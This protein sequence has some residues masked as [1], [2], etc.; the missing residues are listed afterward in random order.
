MLQNF[1][2]GCFTAFFA[3]KQVDKPDIQWQNNIPSN[4]VTVFK[5]KGNNNEKYIKK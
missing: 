1:E 4:F 2:S 3:N 5:W